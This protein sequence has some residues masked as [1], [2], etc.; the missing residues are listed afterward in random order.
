MRELEQQAAR[1]RRAADKKGADQR[2]R[3][4]IAAQLLVPALDGLAIGYLG[5]GSVEVPGVQRAIE[6]AL[7]VADML[8]GAAGRGAA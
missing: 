4:T 6:N 8:I 7:K 2:L 1:D 5:E 3:L